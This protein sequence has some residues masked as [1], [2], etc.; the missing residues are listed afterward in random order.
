MAIII[1]VSCLGSGDLKELV[2]NEKEY[3]IDLNFRLCLIE[4]IL[5]LYYIFQVLNPKLFYA[6]VRV[7]NCIYPEIHNLRSLSVCVQRKKQLPLFYIHSQVR[8]ERKEQMVH[9]CGLVRLTA[10]HLYH[11]RTP[12]WVGAYTHYPTD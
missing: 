9:Y 7:K 2:T 11:I 1:A 8:V 3:T 4:K 10:H 5:I 6:I 12:P